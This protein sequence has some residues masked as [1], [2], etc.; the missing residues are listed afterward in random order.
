MVIILLL[1]CCLLYVFYFFRYISGFDG[2]EN[3]VVGFTTDFAEYCLMKPSDEY[4]PLMENVME[5]ITLTKLVIEFLIEE[6]YQNPTYE[7]LLI[8]LQTSEKVTEESLLKHAQFVCNQ[9]NF[10]LFPIFWHFE[11]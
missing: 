10:E 6:S 1:F 5:K 11:I 8:K 7:D 2:G 3:A 4:M 9:V